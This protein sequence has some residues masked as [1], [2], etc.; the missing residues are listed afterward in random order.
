MIH[1]S[2]VAALGKPKDA[3]I[4]INEN[5]P[6][7]DSEEVSAYAESKY[8]S[9]LEV[10]RGHEEGLKVCILNPSVVLGVSDWGISSTQLFHY[11]YQHPS[12]D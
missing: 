11:A 6:W 2:S 12:F 4:A 8:L 9:E 10:W 3:R 1:L 5:S 7:L